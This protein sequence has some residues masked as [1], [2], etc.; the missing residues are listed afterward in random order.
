MLILRGDDVERLL[1]LDRLIDAVADAMMEVS[2]G[3]VSMPPRVAASVDRPEGLL[4]AM[5]A[6]LPGAGALS[7]KLVS[8]FPGN[9]HRG[10]PSHQ[11]LI[12]MFDPETGTPA[13]LMD[14]EYITAM[15]TA[16]GSALSTRLLARTGASTLAILGTGVEARS[17]G[18]MLPRV[19]MFSRGRVAGRDPAKA[20]KL[21]SDLAEATGVPFDAS[22]SFADAVD[23]ADV[24]CATTHAAEPVVR[25]AWLAPGSHVTSIGFNAE[26]SEIDAALV[27]CS[28]VVVESRVTSL[29]PFPAGAVELTAA[30]RDGTL[31]ADE[32]VEIGELV[33]GVRTGRTAE[34]Q[35]TLYKSVGVAAQDA[36]AAALVLEA[37]RVQGAGTDVSL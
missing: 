35:I 27:S 7:T 26:G 28:M 23:G 21:A 1:D 37:A 34:D 2:A 3:T 25:S 15:R 14:G 13:A 32:V 8:V 24:V 17:H 30:I 29:A 11:A 19:R 22:T 18:M 16:A 12:A 9:P 4:V 36:A 31:R 5:P 20:E 6:Y 10:R 33:A